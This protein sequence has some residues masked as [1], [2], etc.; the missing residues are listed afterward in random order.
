MLHS[1]AWAHPTG[2]ESLSAWI[3]PRF[4]MAGAALLPRLDLDQLDSESLEH[5]LTAER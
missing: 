3:G 1:S 5:R 4:Q 2:S